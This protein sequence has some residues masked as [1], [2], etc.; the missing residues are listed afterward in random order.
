[1]N[2]IVK[3]I[4][5]LLHARKCWCTLLATDRHFMKGQLRLKPYL[6]CESNIA[7]AYYGSTKS[8]AIKP[9]KVMTAARTMEYNYN[10]MKKAANPGIDKA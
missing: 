10:T 9:L 8:R 7:A 3:C 5:Q 2:S 4:I 1:M 6:D